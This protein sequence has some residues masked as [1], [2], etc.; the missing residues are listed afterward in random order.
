[1]RGG[2]TPQDDRPRYRRRALRVGLAIAV[3]V[4]VVW[5]AYDT[6]LRE[7]EV[8]VEGIAGRIAELE[9]ARLAALRRDNQPETSASIRM[10]RGKA[11]DRKGGRA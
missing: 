2:W 8:R 5:F 1:M 3:L 4:A 7:G 10:R 11:G 9:A 6:G